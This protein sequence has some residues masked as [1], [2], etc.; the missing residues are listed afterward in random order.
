RGA[1]PGYFSA[2]GIPLLRGRIFTADER[3][4]RAHV[5][6]ISQAAARAFFPGEDPIG[7]H[8]KS[9]FNDQGAEVVGVVGDTRW[10]PSERPQPTLYWPIYGNDYSG[11][12][13]VVRAPRN[14]DSL[15]MPVQKIIG[16]LDPD[17]PVSEVMT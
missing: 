17:L 11:A 16:Q 7:K 6:V 5:A 2:I 4:D 10:F 15:A 8:L 1:E 3:L 12:T 9:T 14:V 13:I